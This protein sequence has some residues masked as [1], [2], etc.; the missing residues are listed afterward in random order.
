[1]P[2]KVL[3]PGEFIFTNEPCQIYTVLGSCVAVTY[4]HKD[5]KTGGM[6]HYM[7]VDESGVKERPYDFKNAEHALA[8]LKLE[9]KYYKHKVN[10]Y[11]IRLFGAV[12]P[13]DK[14]M[15]EIHSMLLSQNISFARTRFREAGFNVIED[16]LG[17]RLNYMRL[18]FDIGTGKVNLIESNASGAS[19]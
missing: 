4:W 8:Q 10:D 11:Q 3:T 2:R 15:S 12:M 9:I 7:Y 13:I 18:V 14:P 17:E 1:M 16:K 5:K 19:P 6:C